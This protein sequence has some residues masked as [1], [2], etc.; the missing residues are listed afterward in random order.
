MVTSG[1]DVAGVGVAVE[2]RIGV[3]G[4]RVEQ[5]GGRGTW[6][7]AWNDDPKPFGWTETADDI[8]GNLAHYLTRLNQTS[9]D[10]GH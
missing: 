6:I 4:G 7:A 5:G 3:R 9:S 2:D 8:L 10:S 1:E